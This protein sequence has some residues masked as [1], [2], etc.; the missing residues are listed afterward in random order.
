MRSRPAADA[1][2]H[3]VVPYGANGS[4]ARVRAF[5]WLDHT[6]VRAQVHDYLGLPANT[7][8]AVLRDPLAALRAEAHLWR[9]SARVGR[10]TVFLVREASPFSRG[11]AEAAILR[12]AARAVYDFDDA[13]MVQAPGLVERVFSKKTTWRRCIDQADVVIAGNELLAEAAASAGARDVRLIPSCVEPDAYRRKVDYARSGPPR[14]VWLGSPTTENYLDAVQNPL[15]DAHRTSGLRLSVISAGDRSLGALDVMVDRIAWTPTA[16]DRLA[17]HDFGI[18]PLPDDLWSRGKCAYKLLQYG[19]AG[20]PMIGAPVGANRAALAV[21]GGFAASQ[22]DEWR[23]A[24]ATL[25]IMASDRLADL[26]RTAREGVAKH[27]SFGVWTSAWLDA[28]CGEH[29]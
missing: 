18:M 6:G 22:G 1:A 3:V 26:G 10:D 2:L 17:D 19:A 25:A 21:M 27:Y 28:V 29:G 12:R 8:A 14:A 4:S 5:D 24:L 20:L 16:N 7:P 11:H 23:D 15:L 13:L 9:L